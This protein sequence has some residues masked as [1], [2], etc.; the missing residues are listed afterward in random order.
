MAYKAPFTTSTDWGVARVDGTSIT[1]TN[2]IISINAVPPPSLNYG[3]FYDTTTQTNP[4]ASAI[5]IVSWNTTGTNDQVAISG[6]NLITVDNAGTYLKVFTLSFAKIT[7]GAPTVADI[8]LRYNGVDI[9]NSTQQ[10]EVPN[11][12]SALF[13]TGNYT[14]DMAA[15]STIGMCWSSPDTAVQ[16]TA[17]PAAVG[18]VRPAI[19]S[20][21]ITLTR[22]S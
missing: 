1:A 17:V 6:G 21:K 4:V 11:Q 5:N 12:L 14:L 9:T 22:I 3:F 8:W 20:A 18:P 15:G 2:G 13:I 7:P 19:P 16:L 10:I